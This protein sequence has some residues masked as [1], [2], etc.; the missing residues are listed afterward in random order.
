M[1]MK[2]FGVGISVRDIM[3][4]VE[5]YE[6]IFGLESKN[7]DYFPEG[8]ECYGE[9]QHAELWKGDECL[10]AVM[11]LEHSKRDVDPEKQIIGFGAHFDNEAE[12]REVFAL[13]SEGGIVKDPIGPVP[14][15]ACCASVIDKFGITWWISV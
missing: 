3:E 10:F 1:G 13:L 4:T 5:F 11:G 8:H 7:F 9:C 2:S 15:S 6:K 14:W 12:L